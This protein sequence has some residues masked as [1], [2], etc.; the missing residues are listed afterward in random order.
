M[1]PGNQKRV[2]VLTSSTG[3]GH[4]MRAYA[5]KAWSETTEGRAIGLRVKVHHALEATHPVYSFGVTLYNRI[6]Q[7]WPK[8]HH[9]YFNFLEHACMHDDPGK[10]WGKRR[11]VEMIRRER[12]DVIVSTHGH[13]NHGFIELAKQALPERPPKFV[14]YCGEL[15]GGYGFSRHWVNPRADLFIGAVTETCEAASQIG[16]PDPA[17]WVGGFLLKPAFYQERISEEA[18]C[19]YIRDELGLD[20]AGF[21]LVLSTGLNGANNHM[22]ALRALEL[23]KVRPQ[24]VAMCGR[25]T[26]TIEQILAWQ[27]E[28]P[29]FR[30]RPLPY[31]GKMHALLQSASAVVARS[32]T[33]TT[34][35][36][37]MSRCPIIFNGVGGVMPQ[38]MITVK[39]CRKRGFGEVLY[40][41]HQLPGIVRRWMRE[42][43]A[44]LDIRQK[45]A[46]FRPERDPID[47]LEKLRSLAG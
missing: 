2:L 19:R 1:D 46:A 16:M 35:E 20:P 44:L 34:S 23:Q 4:N 41:T 45:M 9:I 25:K 37:V 30:I 47:I 14:I 18:R 21:I 39:Y 42:P 27:R 26:E 3:G 29:E 15:A 31:Y 40:R 43:E 17:N 22:R 13:L 33:G 32:G 36:A 6:Q 5:L 28:H 24:V 11:F 12:P 8:L 10:I 7:F 38:E